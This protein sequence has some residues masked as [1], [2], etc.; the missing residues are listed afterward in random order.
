VRNRTLVR[1][2]ASAAATL[3][4]TASTA[5]A[6]TANPVDG[7]TA[8]TGNDITYLDVASPGAEACSTRGTAVAGRVTVNWNG[9]TH[10]T[11]GATVTI[12]ATPSAAAAL[13]GITASGSTATVP[14]GTAWNGMG[15]SFTAAISTTTPNSAANAAY[16]VNVSVTG[17]GSGPVS[18]G[19][20]YTIGN[21]YTDTLNCTAVNGSPTVSDPA[22]DAYGNEGDL[23]Q[24]SGAFSDPD[25]DSLTLTAD[26]TVGTFTGNGDGTWSWSYQTTEPVPLG[27]IIVTANDGHGHTANNSFH[28]QALNAAP[29][30]AFVSPAT[31]ADEGEAV[32]FNFTITDPGT[33]EDYSFVA[34]SPACGTG[35]TVSSANITGKSGSFD[36]T[37]V[38]GLKPAV[39]S[40]VTAQVNDEADDS[41]AASADVSVANV[42]PTVGPVAFSPT[43]INCGQSSDL[44]GISFSDPGLYDDD[45]TIGIDWGDGSSEPDATTGTQGTY[46]TGSQPHT[47]SDPG[48]YTATVD[49]TDKDG[50]TGSDTAGITVNQTYTVAFLQP[51]DGATPSYLIA[52]TMK[53]GRVVPV[54]VTIKDDCTGAW[55]TGTTGETVNVKVNSATF[56]VS[57]GQVDAV[58]TFS[59]SG[60]SSGNTVAFRWTADS[61]I[62]GGGFW[63]YNLDSGGK[64]WGFTVGPHS[65]QVR[66][67]VDGI[68]V[69][70]TYAVLKPTK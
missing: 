28:Y 52:N 8:K 3:V 60:A 19:G 27:V 54:K 23:L 55:V 56:T 10:F 33:T 47:Y 6:D 15:D 46:G 11:A 70:T 53:L 61:S 69:N 24:A 48:A 13:Q 17:P 63:I 29:A 7:D 42:A 35:N 64:G 4:I 57:P 49:V 65:Y 25:N 31:A 62:A 50:D 58:E 68:C 14:T 67:V 44:T 59:D 1:A 16:T 36:C 18:V 26:N 37:F 34:G 22:E 43:S 32:T 9:A 66:V 21:P 20:V 39:L 51:L 41:N 30:V 38:D 12:T 40:S 2:V 45:W 5:F